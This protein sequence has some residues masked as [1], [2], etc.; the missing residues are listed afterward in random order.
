MRQI[1]QDQL[2]VEGSGIMKSS[3]TEIKNGK[4]MVIMDLRFKARHSTL[5]QGS[6]LSTQTKLKTFPEGY[7]DYL[8][9]F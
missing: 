7:L 5:K 1:I 8:D 3:G 2:L 4:P 6:T 9:R